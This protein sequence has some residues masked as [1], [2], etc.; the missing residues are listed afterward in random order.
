MG[1][2]PE[3]PILAVLMGRE[4]LPEGRAELKEA[5]VP[6]YIFPE[7]AARALAAL[8]RHRVW[9][10]RAEG[11]VRAF[12]VDAERVRDI[13]QGAQRAARDQL[14]PHEALEVLSAYGIATVRSV[15]TTSA[16]E[17]ARAAAG[18]GFPVAA[19]VVSEDI[20]H[21][22]DAGGVVL[23]LRSEED[24]A[25]AYDE[26]VR[27]ARA[28]AP[29]AAIDGVL[30]QPY[31]R[32]GRETII[33]MSVDPSFGPVLMFGLGG[34]HVEVLSDVVFRVQPVTD[35]DARE[36]VHGIRGVR[37]LEGVRGEPPS[38]IEAIV[39]AVQRV[40]QLVGDFPEIRE[41][42]I[43]PFLVFGE[44]AVAVDA[45]IRVARPDHAG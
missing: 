19:K 27:R 14:R 35:L 3:K 37:L 42:D 11:V 29:E 43:N 32:R 1:E 16:A 38:D 15:L 9:R 12:A 28:Y 5:N 7:S 26:I 6:A 10:D 23:D 2:R 25:G 22:T 8:H 41:L 34:I 31:V 4:G 40:S 30:L 21:K 20:V 18:I 33:G 24:V 13:L 39:E 36:M 17:A 45:R 44:G